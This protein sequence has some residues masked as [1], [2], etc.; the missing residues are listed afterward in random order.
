MNTYTS[1]KFACTCK[2]IR[3]HLL[4]DFFLRSFSLIVNT[5]LLKQ[6]YFGSVSIFFP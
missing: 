6:K 1:V 5:K 3:I 2:C 4:F